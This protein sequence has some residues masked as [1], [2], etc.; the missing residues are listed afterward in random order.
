MYLET[1]HHPAAQQIQVATINRLKMK[2]RTKSNGIDCG[3]FA[4]RHMET[5]YGK[6]PW[7]CNLQTEGPEQQSRLRRLRL[8]YLCKIL[9]SDTNQHRNT[10]SKK[11]LLFHENDEPCLTEEELIEELKKRQQLI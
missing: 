6:R 1:I 9:L 4:M 3:I 8:K 5:Y 2:W 7:R 10:V 11:A